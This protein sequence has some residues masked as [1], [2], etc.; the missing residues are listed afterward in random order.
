M[1]KILF[2]LVTVVIL[3]TS[4]IAFGYERNITAEWNS[5]TP[6]QGLATASFNLYKEGVLVCNFEGDD[7]VRGE[8]TVDLVKLS[9][10]FTLTALFSDGQESPHSAPFILTDYGPGPDGLKITVVTVRTVSSLTKHGNVISKTTI[11]RKPLEEGQIVK[12]GTTG[13]RNKK[14][15]EWVSLTV[16][17]VQG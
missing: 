12:E 13:Y 5:Y 9:T 16:F 6:P 14:T 8:C 4:Y 7:I 17:K 3:F 10:P 1:K 15:G 2:G 11:S